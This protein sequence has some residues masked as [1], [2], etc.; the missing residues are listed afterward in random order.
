MTGGGC[1]RARPVHNRPVQSDI[2]DLIERV[3]RRLADIERR[4]V[5]AGP[6]AEDAVAAAEERLGTSF[7]PSYREF[8]RRY[9]A[10]GIPTDLAV[11]HDFCGLAA[12]DPTTDVVSTTLSA[13]AANQLACAA[14]VTFIGS[15]LASAYQPITR[16]ETGPAPIPSAT[17]TV[18]PTGGAV[19]LLGW[20][21]SRT[22]LRAAVACGS[23]L[24]GAVW[25]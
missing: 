10:L 25:G 21:T 16:Y 3:R 12:G 5:V 4:C 15:W 18:G 23:R 22:G 2:V 13:R 19:T 8:L 7:P 20:R 24:R 1:A 9:G 17:A 6:A 14:A 11:V